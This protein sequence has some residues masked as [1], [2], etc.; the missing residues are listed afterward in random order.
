MSQGYP[1]RK[2]V[3][4][5]FERGVKTA[6]TGR[7]FNPYK[8]PVLKDLYERGKNR[9]PK[10]A[11]GAPGT[12]VASRPRPTAQ[13]RPAGSRASAH[14]L[15]RCGIIRSIRPGEWAAARNNCGAPSKVESAPRQA[16][17]YPLPPPGRHRAMRFTAS[18]VPLRGPCFRNASIAYWLQVG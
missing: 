8:N 16:G 9:T 18:H 6:R 15:S 10:L 13:A 17:S 4:K 1:S 5:A 12:A 14:R 3:R 7:G 2:R 11:D